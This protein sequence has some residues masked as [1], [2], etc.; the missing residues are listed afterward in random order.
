MMMATLFWLSE[1]IFRRRHARY[2]LFINTHFLRLG[3]LACQGSACGG[4]SGRAGP[5]TGSACGSG[6]LVRP[7]RAL[8]GLDGP[9]PCCSGAGVESPWYG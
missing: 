7:L 1:G 9:V 8:S 6:R 3:L 2:A 5:V 4:S